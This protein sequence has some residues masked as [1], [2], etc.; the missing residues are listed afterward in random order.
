MKVY[1]GCAATQKAIVVI[2][3]YGRN[4]EVY[5][6][7]RSKYPKLITG[8]IWFH[9]SASLFTTTNRR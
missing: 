2:D 6:E 5:S 3:Q 1:E 7:K 8:G 4:A 9:S